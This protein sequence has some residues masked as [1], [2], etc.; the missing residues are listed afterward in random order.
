MMRLVLLQEGHGSVDAVVAGRLC[1]RRP[2]FLLA[3]VTGCAVLKPSFVERCLPYWH[4]EP[5]LLI[6]VLA[7]LSW[8]VRFHLGG[9]LRAP[10]AGG[11][12]GENPKTEP[13]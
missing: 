4:Y 9:V 11:A 13:L 7:G 2:K 10:T 5:F 1:D 8:G 3:R 12:R 6:N